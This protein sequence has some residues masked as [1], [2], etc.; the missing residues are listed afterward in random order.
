MIPVTLYNGTFAVDT[1]AF[2]DEGSSYTLVEKSLASA[3]LVRGLAQPLR[4]TWTAGVTRLEEDSQRVEFLI[5][6]RGSTHKF[7]IVAAH[8][9]NSL[10]LPHQTVD[11]SELINEHAHL[12]GLPVKY[13]RGIPQILIGLKDI[14]L[15]APIES[16]IGLPNERN[17]CQV[18]A[19]L[20]SL[21]TE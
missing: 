15:Y 20:D 11:V 14:H 18:K 12:R 5:S 19:W 8:T 13:E 2:L 6:A 3:L 10:K 1:I 17:Y 7:R 16:R 4:V 21:W 9:V